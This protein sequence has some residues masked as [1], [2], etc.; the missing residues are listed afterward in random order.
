MLNFIDAR[1]VGADESERLLEILA[2][3]HIGAVS[4]PDE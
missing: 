1:R 4:L 2:D 3:K